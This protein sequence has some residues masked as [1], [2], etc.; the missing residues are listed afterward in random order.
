MTTLPTSLPA[1]LP[2][3]VIVLT[4][5][6]AANIARC[7]ESVREWASEIWIVDSGS[8][9]NTLE[10][11]KAYT[12][13]ITHHPFENYSLQ[14]NWAQEN[15]DLGQSWVFHLDADEAV[16]PSLLAE[17]TAF[18]QRAD[19]PLLHGALVR[20]RILFLGRELRH[21]GLYPT[22]HCRLFRKEHGRCEDRN[23]DQHFVV[24]GTLARLEADIVENTAPTL[25]D[26]TCRHA[27]WA[28]FEASEAKETE[29]GGGSPGG[30]IQ[31]NLLGNPIQRRRWAKQSLYRRAPIFLR[32]FMYFFYRYILRGGFLDGV[33]GLI[34]HVLQGFW[35]RFYVDA[36]SYEFEKIQGNMP[37]NSA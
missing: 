27:R 11:A 35:F 29:Q 9:D 33:P 2:V 21:G 15:L 25:Y 31:S 3:S 8:T 28:R 16:S 37:H 5:N 22:Y 10:M 6:E 24:D 17:L 18:F 14:R 36:Q 1:Q 23:Y 34:Y 20:R 32:A 19:L 7:L 12:D 4:H 13:R 30:R 26:W